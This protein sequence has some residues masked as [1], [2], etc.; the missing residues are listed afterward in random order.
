MPI[1]HTPRPGECITGVSGERV[2][3]S[4]CNWLI[5]YERRRRAIFSLRDDQV[6]VVHRAPENAHGAST[7]AR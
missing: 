6:T 1:D 5:S 4:D 7:E 2:L 3:P